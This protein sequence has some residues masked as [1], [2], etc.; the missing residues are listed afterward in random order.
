MIIYIRWQLAEIICSKWCYV[1][2]GKNNFILWAGEAFLLYHGIPRYY[3]TDMPKVSC[4][5]IVL[6]FDI[7]FC[8]M[9]PLKYKKLEEID[10][11]SFHPHHSK[12]IISDYRQMSVNWNSNY[13]KFHQKIVSF[14]IITISFDALIK[15]P[16]SYRK[17][18]KYILKS[19]V[20]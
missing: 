12:P 10:H 3:Q 15:T 20:Q 2:Y 6:K 1:T 19:E 17:T 18:V 8:E 14:G 4:Y 11:H 9:K 5:S 7:L 16:I 13:Q